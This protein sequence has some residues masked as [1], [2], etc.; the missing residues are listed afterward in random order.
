M[1]SQRGSPV[2]LRVARAD[3]SL[4]LRHAPTFCTN[5]PRRRSLVTSLVAAFLLLGA[6]SG[7]AGASAKA[8][9]PPPGQVFQGVA[10]QPISSY[11][12]AV[13]KHPAVYE[14]FAA[15]G[16]YLPGIFQD[17]ANAQ[18]RLMIHIT[19]ASGSQEIISPQG[20]A[21]GRGDAWLIALCDAMAAS[22]QVTYVRLMAEMDG[23]WNP[24]S[25]YNSDGSSRGAAHS[26]AAFRRAWKRVTLIL[27]GGSLAHINS[28]L[29]RLHMPRL[30]W[31]GDLPRPKVAM[32][33]V[34]QSAGA[35]DIQGNQPIAYWPGQRWV[36]WVGTDFYSKFPNFT[37]LSALYDEFPGEPFV[38]GE[39]ALWGSDDSGFVDQ[40]FGWVRS[41][42]RARMLIYNQG[43]NPEGPF[44]LSLYPS[45]AGALRRQLAGPR[46]P[47][48]APEWRSRSPF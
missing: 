42:P 46:F 6:V 48:Y 2:N 35:P 21:N 24:Y 45:A 32:L 38:F 44:R 3:K 36:D 12:R 22:H 25:A 18:A 17:A 27:R 23:H 13:G 7:A 33:W 31:S 16:E 34:P 1:C 15:W 10:G 28:E 9:L 20:I 19:T 41:H 43:N 8:Y 47:A 5:L 29:A 37:G 14:V 39:Y 11:T 40:L 30:H 4:V 26:T